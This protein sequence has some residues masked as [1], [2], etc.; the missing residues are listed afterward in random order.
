M[1]SFTRNVLSIRSST[2]SMELGSTATHASAERSMSECQTRAPLKAEQPDTRVPTPHTQRHTQ[3]TRSD[4]LSATQCHAATRAAY[5][6]PRTLAGEH[7]LTSAHGRLPPSSDADTNR[8]CHSTTPQ[9]CFHRRST[10]SAT[11]YWR[12]AL[13]PRSNTTSV[14]TVASTV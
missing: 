8:M 3:C 9:L 4:A 12:H 1:E 2:H 5:F 7:P 11:C 13:A 14:S 10:L 6:K